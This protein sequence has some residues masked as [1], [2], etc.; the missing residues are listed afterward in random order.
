MGLSTEKK[1]KRPKERVVRQD[2]EMFL[3]DCHFGLSNANA[4]IRADVW[5]LH[6]FDELLPIQKI[7]SGPGEY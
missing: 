2:L 1:T 3:S 6:A 5:R 4:A 7:N